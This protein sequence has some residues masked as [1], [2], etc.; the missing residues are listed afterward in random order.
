LADNAEA[1]LVV[2]GRREAG[3]GDAGDQLMQSIDQVIMTA[4]KRSIDSG[5][6]DYREFE[7]SFVNLP[8]P[9]I[10]EN[11]RDKSQP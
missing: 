6:F 10:G 7:G 3:E 9:P 8:T 1:E 2:A 4:F 11:Q 5:R